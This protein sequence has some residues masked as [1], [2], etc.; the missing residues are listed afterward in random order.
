MP[1]SGKMGSVEEVALVHSSSIGLPPHLR[2]S[3]A[4]CD[5]GIRAI[6]LCL[7]RTSSSAAHARTLAFT[8]NTQPG[9]SDH[10]EDPHIKE[11]N[12]KREDRQIRG[13]NPEMRDRKTITTNRPQTRLVIN[14]EF[15]SA[16]IYKTASG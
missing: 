14:K 6:F 4:L 3:G 10:P 9:Y 15:H 16:Q 7:W 8:G 1:I 12:Q 5:E 11:G 2:R 13:W